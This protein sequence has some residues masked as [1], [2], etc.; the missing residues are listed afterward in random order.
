MAGFV[1]SLERVI[2]PVAITLGK[3]VH[4]NAIKNGFIRLMP[5]TLVGAIFVLIN[6]VLLNFE[7]G[8][9]FYSMGIHLDTAAIST[10]NDLKA[11]GNS[12]Y[13][14]TLGIMSLMTPFLSAWRWQRSA[15]S[16]RLPQD[17]YLLP[18]L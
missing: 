12:V 17:Y 7:E 5:L 13:N 18:L 2:L 11:T 3:Q 14:G 6:N 9:F 10:L 16:T 1:G 4:V 8:S 15:R